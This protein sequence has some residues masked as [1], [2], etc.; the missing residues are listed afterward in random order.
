MNVRKQVRVAEARARTAATPIVMATLALELP[1]AYLPF[2]PRSECVQW[3]DT[4]GGARLWLLSPE[5]LAVVPD[6]TP[7]VSITGRV[8]I[9]GV[10]HIDTD[11]RGGW[12]SHG[13]LDAQ[14]AE[15]DQ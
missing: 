15:V 9:V 14:I 13:V 7:L 4:A 12:L 2:D 5:Q 1:K 8:S 11:T 3:D 10:D 6:G